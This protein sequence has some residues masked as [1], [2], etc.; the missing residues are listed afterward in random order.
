MDVE[1]HEIRVFVTLAGELHFGRT[2]ERLG[3]TTSRV[4]QVLNALERKLGGG[5]LVRSSRT[6]SLTPLGEQFLAD[7]EPHY[8]QLLTSLE[9][10]RGVSTTVTGTLRLGLLGANSGGP[11]L[12]TIIKEFEHR[13]PQCEVALADL[14]FTGHLGSLRRGDIDVM[15]TRLPIRQP[16]V[17]I[18]PVLSR[19]PR[20]L[21]VADDHPFAG[22]PARADGGPGRLH[23][24]THPGRASRAPARSGASVHPWW[25]AAAEAARASENPP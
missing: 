12:T 5:L 16:D 14:A 22:A 9:Q 15:A 24:R 7:V 8:Q 6:A 21:A 2:A 25:P 17:T 20:V 1:L 3:L 10:L 4:S 23:V 11:H 19:E 18:G 13:Y